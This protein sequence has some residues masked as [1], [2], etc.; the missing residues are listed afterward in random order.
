MIRY[1]LILVTA[2]LATLANA[3]Q[4]NLY[5]SEGEAAAYID[6]EEDATIYL[7]DGSPVAFIGKDGSDVCI[8]GF[9]RSFLGWYENGVVFDKDG[10]MVGSRK[11]ALNMFYRMERFKGFTQ[12]APIRPITPFTPLKPFWKNQWSDAS[13]TEFL[14]L[15]AK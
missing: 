14:Y 5:D 7:W 3:Q 4:V 12:L 11:D 13:L 10:Y 15:G 6:Y 1:W 9:D 8:F 2:L